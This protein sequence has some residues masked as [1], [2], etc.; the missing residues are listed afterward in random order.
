MGMPMRLES[1]ARRPT[2]L[3]LDPKVLEMARELGLNISQT[4]NTLLAEEVKRL[5]WEKWK[6]ENKDAV[7][8][9]NA[10]VRKH[11]IW[12]AKYRTFARSLGDGREE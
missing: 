10:R 5:Y 2:N 6:D 1:S 7:E 12:G 3:T 11:G 9:Y 4:V 8:A